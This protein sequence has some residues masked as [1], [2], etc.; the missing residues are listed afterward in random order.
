MHLLIEEEWR[1][2][3]SKKIEK[4]YCT[5]GVIVEEIHVHKEILR[6]CPSTF[7]SGTTSTLLDQRSDLCLSNIM[8]S[9]ILSSIFSSFG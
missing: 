3:I 2:R 1:E 8:A 5:F 9:D 6:F 4:K 7:W